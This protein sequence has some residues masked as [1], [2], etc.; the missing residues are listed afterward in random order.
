M[1]TVER[2]IDLLTTDEKVRN[3]LWVVAN[4]EPV[5]PVGEVFEYGDSE[6]LEL[7][8]DMFN[9]KVEGLPSRVVRRLAHDPE[10]RAKADQITDE[11]RDTL[12]MEDWGKIRHGLMNAVLVDVDVACRYCGKPV[13]ANEQDMQEHYLKIKCWDR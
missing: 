6:L 4:G 7:V 11:D 13:K 9:G 3:Y 2:M 12:T 1:N 10:L 5:A 8:E